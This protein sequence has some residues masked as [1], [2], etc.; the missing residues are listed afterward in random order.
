LLSATLVATLLDPATVPTAAERYGLER[1]LQ[2]Q[3]ELRETRYYTFRAHWSHL[4]EQDF[5]R[6]LLDLL[7]KELEDTVDE[8]LVEASP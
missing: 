2:M 5:H 6:H 7:S 8:G 4:Q 3:E 1:L